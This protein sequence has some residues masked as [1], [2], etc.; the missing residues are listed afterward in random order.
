MLPAL[1]AVMSQEGSTLLLREVWFL[2]LRIIFWHRDHEEVSPSGQQLV[3]L[4][5]TFI[6]ETCVLP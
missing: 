6:H 4:Q 5:R 3:C 2:T 1:L